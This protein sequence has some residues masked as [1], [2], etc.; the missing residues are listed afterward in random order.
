MLVFYADSVLQNKVKPRMGIIF[1][2]THW[3]HFTHTNVHLKTCS[4]LIDKNYWIRCLIVTFSGKFNCIVCFVCCAC[5]LTTTPWLKL[6]WRLIFLP[7]VLLVSKSD[8]IA[9]AFPDTSAWSTFCNFKFHNFLN[10]VFPK[11]NIGMHVLFY[12]Y[13]FNS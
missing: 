8:S 12:I 4:R 6:L 3:R 9:P 13:N 10:C 7:D 11:M 1:A 5:L 2:N